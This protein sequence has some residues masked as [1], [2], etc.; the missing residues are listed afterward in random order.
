MRTMGQA[1]YRKYRPQTFADITGQEHV[2]ITLQNEIANGS[3][4]HAYIFTGPRG[5]GKTT[6]A[7]L[8]AKAV[9]CQ[10]RKE[11]TAEPC[12]TCLACQEISAGRDVDVVEIDAASNT[13]VD[14]VRENIIEKAR[15][16]PAQRPYKVFIIDEVHM[17]STSAFN[18]LLKSLEEPPAHVLFILATT[19]PH[20]IPAT[21]LSRCQRFDFKRASA[22]DI[23]TRLKGI[24]G[25]ENITVADEVYTLIA[26]ASEG[27]LRDA[28]S[29][30]GQLLALGKSSISLEDARTVLPFSDTDSLISFLSLLGEGKVTEV[31]DFINQL[32]EQG[33]DLIQ[34]SGDA[35]EMLRQLLLIKVGSTQESSYSAEVAAEIQK[36]D[37][38]YASQDIVRLIG[39][40]SNHK[41]RYRRSSH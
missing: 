41:K 26:R 33:V 16:T 14:N 4:A 5:V 7:R 6:T 25:E 31:V 2:K 1:L 17:L 38:Y 27:C 18:A 32:V 11:G 10:N 36:L 21:I 12:N 20:K 37:A 13:G 23:T 19:E 34:F 39:L 40:L 35:I 24:A 8:I 28:E 3:V 22:A 9:N 15:F 29:L 30:F